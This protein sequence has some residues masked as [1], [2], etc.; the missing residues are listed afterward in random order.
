MSPSSLQDAKSPDIFGCH[1]TQFTSC[2]CAC[3]TVTPQLNVGSSQIESG[4]SWKILIPSSPEAVQINPVRWHLFT[5]SFCLNF[6]WRKHWHCTSFFFARAI[7]IKWG[8]DLFGGQNEIIISCPLKIQKSH[9]VKRPQCVKSV[10]S[11]VA[12]KT[13]ITLKMCNDTLCLLTSCSIW[14]VL[15]LPVHIIDTSIV[16]TGQGTN[17]FPG[18][19]T[20]LCWYSYM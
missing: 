15:C 14:Y 11:V 19:I 7:L 17:T 13:W 2:V 16:I 12:S 18:W 9:G 20:S 10:Q 8:F 3:R 5:K 4:S 6:T 1:R